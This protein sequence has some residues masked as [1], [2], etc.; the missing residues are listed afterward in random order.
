MRLPEATPEI[1]A[2]W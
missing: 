2:L 1:A